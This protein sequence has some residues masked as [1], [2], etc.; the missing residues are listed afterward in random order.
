MGKNTPNR[1]DFIIDNLRM[2][3][4][5]VEKEKIEVEA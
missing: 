4:D 5:V 1:Q 2:E 3:I